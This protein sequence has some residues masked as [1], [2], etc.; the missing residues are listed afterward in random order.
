MKIIGI[1][2]GSG[3]GKSTVAVSLCKKYPDTFAL[4]HIDDYFIK[5]EEAPVL[6]GF[7]NWDHPSV[8]RFAELQKDLTSLK[9]GK[10]ITVSTKSELYNPEYNHAFRNK[11][12]YTIEPKP[13]VIL[14]GYLALSDNSIRDMLDYK[15]YLDIP[16]E[17]S[18]KRRSANKFA[19]DQGYFEKVHLPMHKQFVESTKEHADI[20]LDV[21]K[22]SPAQVLAEVESKIVEMVR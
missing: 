18:V 9:E 1:A 2:G 16:L 7:T 11:L 8:V 21:S 10:A 19:I 20:V 14:E 6:E 15:I 13:V 22:M 5:K 4:L 12:E 3:S 17:E